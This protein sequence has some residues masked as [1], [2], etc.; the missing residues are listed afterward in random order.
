[1]VASTR[2][3]ISIS[4]SSTVA[5]SN[6]EFDPL[7]GSIFD[8]GIQAVAESTPKAHVD[9]HLR[10]IQVIRV[11]DLSCVVD[12]VDDCAVAGTAALAV[13]DFQRN[14]F[15]SRGYP[16]DSF[17]IGE[18]CNRSGYVGAMA[19]AIFERAFAADPTFRPVFVDLEIPGGLENTES[20]TKA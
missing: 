5:S 9:H 20:I 19:V 13:E 12:R 18:C 14:H 8:G 17:A 2:R 16:D 15:R 11:D 1:M 10:L 4:I 7:F 3:R 6:G